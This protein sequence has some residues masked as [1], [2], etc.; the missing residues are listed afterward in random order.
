MPPGLLRTSVRFLIW[1]CV[2]VLGF[3]SLLPAKKWSQPPFPGGLEPRILRSWNNG[4]SPA[5]QTS[6][7]GRDRDSMI[8]AVITR[9]A[10]D[11]SVISTYISH[12]T[13]SSEANSLQRRVRRHSNHLGSSI[14]ECRRTRSVSG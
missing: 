5:H 4:L 11:G 3:L 7:P 12:G 8:S 6:L 13:E 9:N 14:L 1:V 2:V 10:R